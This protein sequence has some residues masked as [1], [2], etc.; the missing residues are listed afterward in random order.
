MKEAVPREA[1]TAESGRPRLPS[2]FK[3]KGSF[4]AGRAW[5]GANLS[6]AGCSWLRGRAGGTRW[7]LGRSCQ[8]PPRTARTRDAAPGNKAVYAPSAPGLSSFPAAFVAKQQARA[9]S[10]SGHLLLL[11]QHPGTGSALPRE[12]LS[13]ALGGA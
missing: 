7:L 9:G 5:R 1:T 10:I 8:A 6:P 12:A 13:R 2:L 11:G 3:Y 4:A